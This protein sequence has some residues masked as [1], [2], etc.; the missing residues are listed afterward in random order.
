MPPRLTSKRLLPMQSNASVNSVVAS[1]SGGGTDAATPFVRVVAGACLMLAAVT[2][3]SHDSPA[4]VSKQPAQGTAVRTGATLITAP[5]PLQIF[6]NRPTLVDAIELER[7]LATIDQDSVGVA[8]AA[9]ADAKILI[10]HVDF[11]RMPRVSFSD[12][13]ILGLQWQKGEL[14]VALI[15]A[16]DGIASI[17]FRRPGQFYAENG[18]DIS[19]SD[20]LPLEF[21]EALSKIVS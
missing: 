20:Q 3:P 17:A 5:R 14:G 6:S 8:D 4:A 11:G 15:F 10:Q 13:G 9:A 2:I 7:K 1:L 21:N 12:D 16:G 19:V 18:I